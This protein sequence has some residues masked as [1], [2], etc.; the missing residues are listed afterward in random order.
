MQR[1][2]TG[3][4]FW[5]GFLFAQGQ[6]VSP[7]NLFRN[8]RPDVQIVVSKH[9]TGADMFE[10]TALNS[11]FS[12]GSLRQSLVKFGELLGN[13]PRGLTF[14]TENVGTLHPGAGKFLRATFAISGF[15]N[16]NRSV[17]LQPLVRAFAGLK[18]SSEVQGMDLIL[19]GQSESPSLI[20]TYISPAVEV[21]QQAI[22]NPPATDFRIQI[23]S[24]D[25]NLISIP[26]S[27]SDVVQSRVHSKKQSSHSWFLLGLI[28]LIALSLAVLVYNLLLGGAKRSSSIRHSK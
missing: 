5:I 10:V 16:L 1:V 26:N 22:G 3:L 23:L 8:V 19:N 2:L 12:P 9:P 7:L 18:G 4:L 20:Q 21:Q 13:P 11:N 6:V 14:F 15:W 24:Q 27:N 25:P 17:L 28:G